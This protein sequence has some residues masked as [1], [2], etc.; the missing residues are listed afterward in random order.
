M[1][2][3]ADALLGVQKKYTKDKLSFTKVEY[4][5]FA[6]VFTYIKMRDMFCNSTKM[7]QNKLSSC[8]GS[9]VVRQLNPIHKK[10][11]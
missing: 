2:K 1:K 5:Y 10:G 6:I 11:T 4:Y 8:S 3:V 7:V 9:A